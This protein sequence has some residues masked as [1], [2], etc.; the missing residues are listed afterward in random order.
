MVPYAPGMSVQA[1]DQVMHTGRFTILLPSGV[2]LQLG[3]RVLIVLVAQL[4]TSST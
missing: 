1:A 2:L 4:K 3:T